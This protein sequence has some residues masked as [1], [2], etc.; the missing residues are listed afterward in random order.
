MKNWRIGAIN[1]AWSTI[2]LEAAYAMAKGFILMGTLPRTFKI[3]SIAA[4]LDGEWYFGDY[5]NWSREYIV[6]TIN[7]N[8]KNIETF[9]GEEYSIAKEIAVKNKIL[10]EEHDRDYEEYLDYI[11]GC[12]SPF[13][14]S[15][16]D[17]KYTKDNLKYIDSVCR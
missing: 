2:G 7:N 6:T 12:S 16:E 10:S 8:I 14:I 17:S 11:A 13:E 15:A 9:K 3:S 4:M 5:D 1:K